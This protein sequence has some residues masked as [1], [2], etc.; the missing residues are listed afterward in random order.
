MYSYTVHIVSL[1]TRG[2]FHFHNNMDVDILPC[3]II[4]MC[5]CIIMLTVVRYVC[6][7][8][9]LFLSAFTASP[10]FGVCV[11]V[12]VCGEGGGGVGGTYNILS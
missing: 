3:F 4:V 6:P 9:T 12:C 5:A 8:L 1:I 2:A 7:P 10:P 11:C